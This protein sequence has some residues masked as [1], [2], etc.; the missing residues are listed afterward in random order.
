MLEHAKVLAVDDVPA[1][2]EIVVETLSS[3][4]CKVAAATSGKRVLKLLETYTP[5]L[6]L[7]DIQMPEMDGFEVCKK[8]KETPKTA[9]IPIIF[10]TAVSDRESVS[11]GFSLGA[12][13][14][15]PKPFRAEELLARVNNHIQLRQINQGLEKRV[16]ERTQKL[17]DLLSQLKV[18]QLQLIQQEKM[19]AL[20][21]LIAGVAHEINNPVSCVSGNILELTN[22]LTD[23]FSYINL[24]RQQT[25]FEEQEAY[26]NQIDLDFLIND[27]PKM[28]VSMENA[29][30]RIMNI[31]RSLRT[32]SR[33]DQDSKTST[34]L[35]ESLES[36][37]LILKHRLKA[38]EERPQIE[39]IRRYGELPEVSCF[40]GRLHQVFMNLLANAID[41]I[42]DDNRGKTY[43]E[44][45]TN[46][47]QITLKTSC[48]HGE[49]IISIKDNGI[50]MT[51]DV[52]KYMFEHLYT[53]K[54]PGRGT[55]LGLA[56]VKQII[57]EVH[58]GNIH[59][60][61]NVGQGTEFTLTLP[62][63]EATPR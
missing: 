28:M 12:V 17:E 62:I 37:L 49:A 19:S 25:P 57:V 31:S 50:G 23:I 35:H 44:I 53:T 15:I 39:V 34:D 54:E 33:G 24:C 58:G 46:P 36:S 59:V 26:A 38:N 14:Y 3:A 20:G 48:V 41:A 32:F 47:N 30:D 27:L 4:G 5:D 16:Q 7:L 52:Q 42:E 1:N 55:G 10:I 51:D 40:P 29:C 21:N 18:S 13:D 63:G 11:K 56:I 2:L 60:D 22:N 45:Q 43:E 61:S 9:N 8:L 6:I